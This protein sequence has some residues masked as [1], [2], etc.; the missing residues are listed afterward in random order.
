M[1]GATKVEFDVLANDKASTKLDKIAKGF[2]SLGKSAKNIGNTAASGLGKLTSGVSKAVGGIAKVGGAAA[3]GAGVAVGAA[4]IGGLTKAMDT[5]EANQQLAAQLG[6]NKQESAKSG[7]IAGSLYKQAYGDSVAG[8]DDVLKSVFQSGIVSIKSSE[9]AIQGV[10]KQVMNFAKISGEEA[11]PVTRAVAQ[12]L[13]TGLAKNAT[14]AF[15]ILT[16]G[17]QLGINKSEDLL[18]TFNEYGTQ[19]RKIGLD[20]PTALGLM[21]QALQAGA[22][23]SDIAAD[24]IKEFSIRAVDGSKSTVD[25]F[26]SLGL[27][28]KGMQEQIAGGGP[29]AAAGLQTV[30][31]KLR[32]I[33]D[34]AERARIAVELFG[35]QAEDLGAALFA[36]DTS[37]AVSGLGK[38]KGAAKDAGDTLNDTAKSKFSSII[39]TIQT[40]LV[41]AISKY[42]LPSLE[43]F[44]DWFAGPGQFVMA[45]W[46]IVGLQALVSLSSGV[47]KGLGVI[48]NSAI[49]FGLKM[50]DIF[51]KT[52]GKLPGNKK[53]DYAKAREQIEQYRKGVQDNFGKTGDALDEWNT[54][55]STLQDEV[56]FKANIADLESKLKDAKRLLA[57]KNLTKERKAQIQANIKDLEDKLRKARGDL[58]SPA[59]TATKIAKLQANKTDLD[60]KIKAAQYALAAPSLTATKR[61]KLE[62]DIAQLIKA[63]NQ[64]QAAINAL[65][66]KTVYVQVRAKVDSQLSTHTSYVPG[67]AVGGPV[68]KNQPYVVGEH[69]AELFIPDQDGTIMPSVPKAMGGS[70]GTSAGG[71]VVLR[72]ESGGSKMDD[73]IVA[74]I[75]K[76]VANRGGGNVQVALGRG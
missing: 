28:A 62:A 2:D 36:M 71:T 57:D 38:L 35:T 37:T 56:K 32:G 5:Q 1:A 65:T 21:N 47:N 40:T 68:K 60:A 54:D 14:E 42:A 9:D 66:G 29:K 6:F 75:Q 46:V 53:E 48:L 49:D 59:L 31:E 18:D 44:A 50:T 22:R 20:G 72:I 33:K 19:F 39:R 41:D 8:I 67:R 15:D 13:K 63:R 58:A 34:P 11:L 52:I 45:N 27:S 64:A 73:L 51:E 61:A 70:G 55:L 4:F 7:K 74:I 16:R 76:A 26:K 30:L 10:T 12:M 24:A 69:R 17:Q 3:V 25:A 43:K 23:D